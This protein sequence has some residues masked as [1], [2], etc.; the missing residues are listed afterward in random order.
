M[1]NMIM[2]MTRTGSLTA[3]RRGTQTFMA[4]A[5]LAGL[6]STSTPLAAQEATNSV[7]RTDA[8]PEG[9]NAVP[10][11]KSSEKAAPP[12]YRPWTVGIEAGTQGI[13]GG[14]GSWRFSDHLGL[15]LGADYA[16]TSIGHVGIAGINYEAKLR[17]LSEPLVLDIYPWQKH[18]F[19]LG[20]GV[21]FNQNELTGTA[22]DP[23]FGTLT[24]KIEQQ[25][26]DPYLT[27]GGNLLYF[28]HP[29]RW[30]L[31]GELGVAYTGDPRVTAGHYHAELRHWAQDYTWWPVAKLAVTFSF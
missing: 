5:L 25:P 21:L 23:H 28:D 10:A 29:H 3:P 16:Q 14:F 4:A 2:R 20:V 30:A 26:V 18:S 17:L 9:T 24:M 27:I 19:H 13:F 15:R 11:G 7:P 22:G 6:A 8:V 1:I 31:S 12:A